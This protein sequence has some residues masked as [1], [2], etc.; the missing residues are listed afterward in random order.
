VVCHCSIAI[1][2]LAVRGH[3]CGDLQCTYLVA[4]SVID[5]QVEPW[6]DMEDFSV[7]RRAEFDAQL[8]GVELRGRWEPE[9]KKA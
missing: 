9:R 3:H 8:S 5:N 7:E 2:D 6:R 4:D 1:L